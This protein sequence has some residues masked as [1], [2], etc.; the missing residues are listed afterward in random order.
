MMVKTERKK[1]LSGSKVFK[2]YVGSSLY[3][4]L[5][6]HILNMPRTSLFGQN[7]RVRGKEI[8]EELVKAYYDT[9]KVY[10]WTSFR[11]GI[12][13]MVHT[14]DRKNNLRGKEGGAQPQVRIP[15]D[16]GFYSP[17]RDM[18]GSNVPSAG[19]KQMYQ[20]TDV[21]IWCQVVT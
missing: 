13:L 6:N 17:Q 8:A 2:A 21:L 11:K 12:N 10:D 5:S 20:I 16:N 9:L 4:K 19:G 1:A 18:D 14:L 3:I 15:Q 7:G